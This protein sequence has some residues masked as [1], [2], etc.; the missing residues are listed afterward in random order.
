MARPKSIPAPLVGDL[1]AEPLNATA[2]E[3]APSV[4]TGFVPL[5]ENVS[6]EKEIEILRFKTDIKAAKRNN[7]WKKGAVDIEEIEHRHFWDSVNRQGVPN[8]HCVARNGHTHHVSYELSPDGKGIKTN[9]GPALKEV[10]HKSPNGKNK[11]AYEPIKLYMVDDD[12]NGGVKPVLDNHTHVITYM[13]TE[14]V[15]VRAD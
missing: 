3:E 11:R 5:V 2:I 14:K 9:C 10:Q 4:P 15:L 7:A 12:V 1:N 13:K 6:S 8:T